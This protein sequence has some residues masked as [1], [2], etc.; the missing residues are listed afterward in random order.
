MLIGDAPG[1]YDDRTGEPFAGHAG[2]L[3]NSM[4]Y[5]IGL[6]KQSVYSTTLLKC[7]LPDNRSP[8]P[9]EINQCILFL[10]KQIALIQPK[11]LLVFGSIAAQHL[12]NTQSPLEQLRGNLYSYGTPA[13]PL[14]ATYHPAHLLLNPQDKNKT[15]KDL[16]MV[17][18]MLSS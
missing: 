8:S 6:E 14:I 2:Q 13:I 9:E 12:L 3:L 11:V 16:Q 18:G 7:R 5:A 17:Y 10:N 4:L 15:W 1:F